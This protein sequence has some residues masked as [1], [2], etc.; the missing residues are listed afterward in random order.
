MRFALGID[1]FI[2]HSG[3]KHSWVRK[4]TFL[5]GLSLIM[6]E[7]ATIPMQVMGCCLRVLPLD[8]SRTAWNS[9]RVQAWFP[10]QE[11]VSVVSPEHWIIL[12]NCTDA[13]GE[14][15]PSTEL[16]IATEGPS[17]R[18]ASCSIF[19]SLA[20]FFPRVSAWSLARIL[21][22][23]RNSDATMVLNKIVTKTSRILTTI[24]CN[25]SML[26]LPRVPA[27][28]ARKR[29]SGVTSLRHRTRGSSCEGAAFLPR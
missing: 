23:F 8:A 29:G 7:Q 9:S 13:G 3:S 12:P 2:F 19:R 24:S 22:C 14:V 21:T 18:A 26:S 27:D 11:H 6:V 4:S 1:D 15:C 5:H 10:T 17:S 25:L 16:P 28:Q 20:E